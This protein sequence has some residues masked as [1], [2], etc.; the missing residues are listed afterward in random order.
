MF[1]LPLVLHTSLPTGRRPVTVR[2]IFATFQRNARKALLQI[3]EINLPTPTLGH[4]PKGDQRWRAMKSQLAPNVPAPSTPQNQQGRGSGPAPA[5]GKGGGKS[6]GGTGDED[7]ES[8]PDCFCFAGTPQGGML[9]RKVRSWLGRI[10][11]EAFPI[12]P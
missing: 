7:I 11:D 9:R 2:D 3:K 8:R 4:V 1:V 5:G 12:N 10:V 6:G